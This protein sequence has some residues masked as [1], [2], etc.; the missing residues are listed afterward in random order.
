M[1]EGDIEVG[2]DLGCR[3]NQGRELGRKGI[4]MDIEH[5]EAEIAFQCR[6]SLQQFKEFRSIV[7]LVGTVC[8]QVLRNQVQFLD[9]AADE[10]FRVFDNRIGRTAA[11]IA[12]DYGNSAVSAPVVAT[13]G[14]L[15]I[16]TA[17]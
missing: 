9:S 8:G 11:Q 13:F 10:P 17:G 3:G 5:T 7:S 12:P 6:Q 2:N 4:G 14:Y 1:L 15:Q 16:C